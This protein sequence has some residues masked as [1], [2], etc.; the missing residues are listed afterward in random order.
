MEEVTTE[1][2][3]GVYALIGLI[4][5]AFYLL[6]IVFIIYFVIKAIKFM[7]AKVKLDNERNQ[8]I[9]ELIKTISESNHLEK[10]K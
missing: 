5:I 1:V 7:N 8:K 6:I 4:P 10:L 3:D 2:P 9:D